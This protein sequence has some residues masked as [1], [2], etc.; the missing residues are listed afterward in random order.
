MPARG[1]RDGARYGSFGIREPSQLVQTITEIFGIILLIACCLVFNSSCMVHGI[2][3]KGKDLSF[4]FFVFLL[5]I[6]V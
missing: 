3:M 2:Q 6:G 5:D 1:G 4:N